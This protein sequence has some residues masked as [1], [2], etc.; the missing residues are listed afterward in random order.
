VLIVAYPIIFVIGGF[1]GSAILF[2]LAK[3]L[4]GKGSFMEHTLGLTLIAGANYATGFP[5]MVLSGIPLVGGL[6]YLVLLPLG[7]YV[8]YD[9]YLMVK[10]IHQFS[11][12]RAA[13]FIILPIIIAIILV[14]VLL[15]ALI[16]MFAGA[17]LSVAAL[18]AGA[19][20]Y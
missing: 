9:Q 11:S 4:G 3:I 14:V 5:F 18:G 8:L 20:G 17:G 1:I 6:F 16:A 7:L 19:G 10:R 13:L 15:G 2:V 12:M